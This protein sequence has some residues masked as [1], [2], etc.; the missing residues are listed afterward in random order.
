MATLEQIREFRSDRGGNTVSVCV[1]CRY[2]SWSD[3]YG[4]PACRRCTRLFVKAI[5]ER[6]CYMCRTYEASC[7]STNDHRKR[8][9]FCD[10]ER[11]YKLGLK[12]IRFGVHDER[13]YMLDMIPYLRKGVA[14][15]YD[16]RKLLLHYE[17]GIINQ[18]KYKC[19]QSYVRWIRR[20]LSEN[21]F[22]NGE[23]E[24]LLRYD[25]ILRGLTMAAM[26]EC[27][28]IH[29]VLKIE[30]M[31]FDPYQ[32]RIL[33][34]QAWTIDIIHTVRQF[35]LIWKENGP[36]ELDVWMYTV[37]GLEGALDLNL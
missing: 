21:T 15:D 37:L 18:F 19:F 32:C 9:R 17:M 29:D 1:N 7:L 36:N 20:Y 2:P 34:N 26:L 5:R 8:C 33:D 14:T 31:Y 12:P 25:C 24:F 22:I 16:P 4:A 6:R 27:I 35:L 30:Y 13:W 10:L 3:Y 23:G 11:L 28:N